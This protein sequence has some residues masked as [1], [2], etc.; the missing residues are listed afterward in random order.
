MDEKPSWEHAPEWAQWLAMDNNGEWYWYEDE[1]EP[2]RRGWVTGRGRVLS[3][4]GARWT[5]TKEQRP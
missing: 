1:P 5:K 4:S 2:A 3:A